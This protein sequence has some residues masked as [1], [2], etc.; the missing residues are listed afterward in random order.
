MIF[1][2]IDDVL[3][4]SQLQRIRQLAATLRFIDGKATN[5]GLGRKHNLQLDQNDPELTE[6]GLIVRA[7]L[8][9]SEALKQFAF[10][11][12]LA[13]PTLC[14][15]QPGM[16]YGRHVDAPLFPSTPSPMRSDLS[17]TVF[18]SD[19]DDYEGG[20]L[21]IH[22]GDQ[23]LSFRGKPGS[24]IVYASTSI[25]EVTPVTR[26]ERIV[27]ISWIQSYLRH[28]E[29]RHALYELQQ[30]INAEHQSISTDSLVRLEAIKSN[31]YRMWADV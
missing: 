3:N 30:L 17:C 11:K 28:G 16:N 25:H 13:R 20:E 5:Q 26:G 24:A 21:V 19:P 10:P 23:A 6:P 15:Y 9:Q 22:L 8:F 7:A 12:T 27:S 18:I 1:L 31:L 2:Q 4:A 14:K 29:H